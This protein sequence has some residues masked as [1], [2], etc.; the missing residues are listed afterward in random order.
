MRI[1]FVGDSLTSGRPGSSYLAVLRRR[2]PHDELINLGKGNDTVV[3]LYRRITA[4]RWNG[5]L[6]MAFLW[7]GVNDV[8]GPASWSLQLAN[9]LLRTPR[10]NS[11]DEFRASYKSTLE[12]LR[13]RAAQVVAVSPLLRGE[14]LG[15]EWNRQLELLSAIIRDLALR[16]ERVDYLDLRLVFADRLAGRRIS[17]YLPENAWQVALDALTLRS[18]EQIDKK[19]AERGLHL[20]LDGLHLNSAGAELAAEAFLNHL[21]AARLIMRPINA[22]GV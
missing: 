7:V 20:T 16:Y 12:F 1:A 9:A 22:G 17:G 5:P 10:S 6:D 8:C 2:L 15:N 14:D 19:A 18:D 11:L 3:S 13:C 21:S 4:L